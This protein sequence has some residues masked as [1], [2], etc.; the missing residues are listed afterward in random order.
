LTAYM[1]AIGQR[2]RIAQDWSLFME[3]YP[4]VLGPVSTLEPFEVGTDVTGL[5]ELRRFFRSIR[6][7]EACNLLG[8]PSLAVPVKVVDGV[9]QAVQLIGRRFHEDLCFD[10]AEL[11]ERQQGVFTPIEPREGA[12]K[13]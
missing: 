4:L 13:V 9:P 3:Q 10:A 7:T 11:I 12:R 6:L 2:Y 1:K 8:L 5:E